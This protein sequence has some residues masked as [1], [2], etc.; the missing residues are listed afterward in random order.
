MKLIWDFNVQ[1][2]II[3]FLINFF[4]LKNK[5]AKFVGETE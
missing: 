1:T 2:Y 3:L 4:A 5:N